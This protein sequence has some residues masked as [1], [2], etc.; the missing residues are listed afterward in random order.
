M[1]RVKRW[2]TNPYAGS[3]CT[4][5]LEN[6]DKVV[7]NHEEG[8]YKTG[9]LTIDRLK[10][11]GFRRER[12]F[13][14]NLDSPEGKTALTFLTRHAQAESIDAMPARAF[15]KYLETCRS[16]DEVKSRC[17]AVMAIHRAAGK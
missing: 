6:G 4:L 7:I 13:V 1:A 14:C 11:L 3:Q 10:L 12:V 2:I 16:I 8:S 9:W 15:V 5:L 17:A